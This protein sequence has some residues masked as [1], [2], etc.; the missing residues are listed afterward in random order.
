MGNRSK[1][2]DAKQRASQKRR[3][4]R[5]WL[6][7]RGHPFAVP[8]MTFLLL[9]F[10]SIFGFIAINGTTVGASDSRLVQVSVDGQTQTLP[11]RAPTVGDLLKRLAV[12]VHEQDLVEPAQDTPILQ[13]NFQV[14]V[15]R[16]RPVTIVDK[17]KNHT[18]LSAYQDPR[19]VAEKAG[20]KLYSEDDVQFKAPELDEGVIG[21]KVLITRATPITI[22]L[23]GNVISTRTLAKTVRDALKDKNIQT[24]PGDTV[25]PGL[26]TLLVPRLGV[27][28]VRVGKKV[29]TQGENIPMP[30]ETISDAGL[31]YGQTVVRQEGNPGRKLVT[32]EVEIHNGKEAS[33]RV[34]QEV[35]ATPPVKR[36]V[37]VGTK[38]TLTGDKGQWLSASRIG[39]GDY[40]YVDYIMSHESGWRPGAISANRCYGLGQSCSGS[41]SNACPNWA[42]DPVCQLNFFD[43]YATSRYGSW[44]GA[45][46]FWQANRWW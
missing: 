8:V 18:V 33:R 10:V 29:V 27:F 43:S 26:D 44:A 14:N 22:N 35:I 34:L 1:F 17:G 11:T 4:Q 23:Y 40:S 32:Y 41:L 28:I 37:A 15:Y 6:Q 36:I 45:Y 38:I 7:L 46:N 31:P 24:L 20:F 12:Q 25:T 19:V 16:A 9:F 30:V 13:D 3:R 5:L 2:I 39:S 42:N 21:Q